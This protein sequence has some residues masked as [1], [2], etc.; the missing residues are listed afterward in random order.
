MSNHAD[1]NGRHGRLRIVAT[2]A[3]AAGAIAATVISTD[4]HGS[5]SR[6]PPRALVAARAH[7]PTTEQLVSRLL[8]GVPQRANV[9]G[10]PKAPLTL[11]WFG[12]LECPFC[13]E[14]ALGA[15]PS[16][17]QRWVRGGQLRIAYRSLRAATRQPAVFAAQQIAA[18]AAGRQDRMWNFI[19]TFYREE[20]EEN[21]GYVTESYLEGIASQVPGLSLAQWMSDRDSPRLFRE[22]AVDGA[23]A[24]EVRLGGTPAFL[25]GRTGAGRALELGNVS[26]TDPASL[27]RVIER[28][29]E[30]RR[31]P[32]GLDA[33]ELT[34]PPAPR[35]SAAA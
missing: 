1:S 12:D 4:G 35:P 26:L 9:L 24:K 28:I 21:S 25:L 8:A 23:V 7:A 34:R 13:K 11:Q 10:S 6:Q 20:G 32:G 18:L 19:E 33:R 15:L 16:I 22:V 3:V 5:S 31:S 17:I 29:L 27:D 2:V 14:F 30:S